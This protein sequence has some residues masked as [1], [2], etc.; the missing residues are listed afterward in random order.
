[1]EAHHQVIARHSQLQAL[2]GAN[3][4][5]DSFVAETMQRDSLRS[6]SFGIV[7]RFQ[8]DKELAEKTIMDLCGSTLQPVR[9]KT[10]PQG[11][12]RTPSN[13]SAASSVTGTSCPQH[14]GWLPKDFQV[15]T[16]QDARPAR[17]SSKS[18]TP[19][20]SPQSPSSSLLSRAPTPGRL[21][22][23]RSDSSLSQVSG[24]SRRVSRDVPE[25]TLA[26]IGCLPSSPNRTARNFMR[27]AF[28]SGF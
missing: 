8:L 15:K 22:R 10:P 18:S 19:A 17:C 21:L 25:K 26:E 3:I 14:R 28:V 27:N 1:M 11:L 12:S 7:R 9:D 23:A 20:D 4:M 6:R 16:D 2:M 5:R 24:P 13:V